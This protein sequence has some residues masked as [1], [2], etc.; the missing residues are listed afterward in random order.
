[1]NGTIS[2]SGIARSVRAPRNEGTAI[3]DR[4]PVDPEPALDGLGVGDQL[5]LDAL[6]EGVAL[7]LLRGAVLGVELGAGVGAAQ[8]IDD[9]DALG[10]VLDV[11]DDPVIL[12]RDLDRRVP[13]AGGRSADQERDLEALALHRAGDVHHLV[14]RRRD[15]AREPDHVDLALAGLLEDLLAG[16]HHAQV[17]DFVVVAGQDDADD[18]LADVVDVSLDRGH[19]DPASGLVLVRGGAVAGPVAGGRGRLGLFGLHE[20]RQVGDGLLHDPRALDDLGQEHLARAEEVADDVHA[21]H[22]AGLR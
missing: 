15:Q 17:D 19:Q 22:Q 16:D 1:M 13:G 7:A 8:A 21:V 9:A 10:G 4:V 14:E 6:A 12:R 3:G 18:V 5:A 11:D 20:R 2:S